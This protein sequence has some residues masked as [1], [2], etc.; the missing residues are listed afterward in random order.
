MRRLPLCPGAICVS[1]NLPY[2]PPPPPPGSV[3]PSPITGDGPI[4]SPAPNYSIRRTHLQM[5][6]LL[7]LIRGKLIKKVIPPPSLRLTQVALPH[8]V[9]YVPLSSRAA[10]GQKR[11]QTCQPYRGTRGRLVCNLHA[12]A[13]VRNRTRANKH[14][15]VSF[16]H[17]RLKFCR[18]GKKE[19]KNPTF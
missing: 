5:T 18:D 8:I 3:Q 14:I 10:D 12:R 4:P 7:Q 9:I 6:P 15:P 17:A 13:H 19:K 2:P 11:R 16:C 1:T